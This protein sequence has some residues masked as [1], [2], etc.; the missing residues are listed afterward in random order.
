MAKQQQRDLNLEAFWR[1]AMKRLDKSGLTARAFCDHE[2]LS[3]P[4]FYAWRRMI[5]QRDAEVSEPAF[6]PVVVPPRGT[7]S[8]KSTA[9]AARA[10]RSKCAAKAM[11]FAV[12]S[13]VCQRRCRCG[14]LRNWFMP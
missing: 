5:R 4:S 11:V 6:L 2:R 7:R 3:E 12:A 14:R 8:A 13:C 9:N 10:F 1:G